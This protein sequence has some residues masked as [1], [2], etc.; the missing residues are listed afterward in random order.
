MTRFIKAGSLA[1]V[2]LVVFATCHH[3]SAQQRAATAK[4]PEPVP[5]LTPEPDAAATNHVLQ[6][7]YVNSA[8]PSFFTS[9]PAGTQPIDA[10][11]TI[12]CP[13]TTG[14]CTI[15][16]DQS[17]QLYATSSSTDLFNFCAELDGS[18]PACPALVYPLPAPG[19]YL[20]VTFPQRISGVSHGTHTVQS[21]IITGNGID[22]G[23]YTFTYHVYKP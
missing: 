6:R 18:A 17:I 23:Y 5:A 16:F 11:T 12:T 2:V 10:L 20:T 8:A 19:T 3:A 22:V 21:A 14:T 13:G 1:I 4:T 7:T 15:E 9:V